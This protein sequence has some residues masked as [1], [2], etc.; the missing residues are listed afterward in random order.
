VVGERLSIKILAEKQENDFTRFWIYLFIFFFFKI[1]YFAIP[2]SVEYIMG[3]T[4]GIW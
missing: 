1:G 4:K 2:W 3:E